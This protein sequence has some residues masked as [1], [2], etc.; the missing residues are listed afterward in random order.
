VPVPSQDIEQS[1]KL[2]YIVYRSACTKPGHW[3]VNE[4]SLYIVYRS[5]CTKP[6]HWAVNE[7][8]LYSL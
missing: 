6:G 5:A 4:T 8:S 3:A 7:T 2:V 1:M